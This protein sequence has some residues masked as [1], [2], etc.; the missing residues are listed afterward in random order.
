MEKEKYTTEDIEKYRNDLIEILRKYH[1]KKH[2]VLDIPDDFFNEVLFRY[3]GNNKLFAIPFELAKKLDLSKADFKDVY[4][5][6]M[7]FKDSYGVRINPQEIAGE[8]LEYDDVLYW[9]NNACY[10]VKDYGDRKASD[11]FLKVEHNL[12]NCVFEGVEFTGP[13]DNSLIHLS[14]FSGSTGVKINPQTLKGEIYMIYKK[15]HSDRRMP[16]IL[17]MNNCVFQDVEFTG[18]FDNCV[19][20][21]SNFTGSMNAN[22][23]LQNL[24]KIK[25]SGCN[26]VPVM[27]CDFTDADVCG[28]W[29]NVAG[30]TPA[31]YEQC[32]NK[33]K[34]LIKK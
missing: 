28:P 2:L 20:C 22:I 14:D 26:L 30:I 11:I 34:Q 15:N 24:K 13:F 8:T 9:V 17:P 1:K 3:Y 25:V 31:M 27:D 19:I 32:E 21:G 4:I 18:E 10:Q 6:G 16:I 7:N 23:Q 12:S 5:V 33:N 29:Y